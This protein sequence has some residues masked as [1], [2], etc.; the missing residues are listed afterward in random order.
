MSTISSNREDLLSAPS[1]TDEG[2]NENSKY[3]QNQG[4]FSSIFGV[5]SSKKKTKEVKTNESNI[6]NNSTSYSPFSYFSST[7][8]TSQEVND[9]TETYSKPSTSSR[10]SKVSKTLIFGLSL[11]FFMQ[12]L[13]LIIVLAIL[14][15]NVFHYLGYGIETAGAG[16]QETGKAVVATGD[17]I[18]EIGQVGLAKTLPVTNKVVKQ[19]AIVSGEGT[20]GLV[21]V[22]VGATNKSVDL[23]T[24]E[25]GTDITDDK[26]K[27]V[28][29]TI[30]LALEKKSKKAKQP[31]ESKEEKQELNEGW[32][33]IGS[34]GVSRSCAWIEEG[35]GCMSGE[36][37]GSREVCI[38]PSLRE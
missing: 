36:I 21:D 4:I 16:V 29:N 27:H 12:L 11:S 7:Q 18:Q 26:S 28:N 38:N 30:D 15:I 37:F 24:G 31:K 32:C 17:K 10:L 33:Y 8:K 23:V 19:T 25:T 14:G 22:T 20:K 34:E 3:K 13:L 5:F 2:N 9:D 35:V 1:T 6:Q